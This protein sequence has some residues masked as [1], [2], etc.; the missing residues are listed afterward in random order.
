MDIDIDQPN[1]FR[2]PKNCVKIIALALRAEQHILVKIQVH[3]FTNICF[4]IDSC[5]RST[6][7]TVGEQFENGDIGRKQ[8]LYLSILDLL[9]N[10]RQ[11]TSYIIKTIL[12]WGA[13]VMIWMVMNH[14][15]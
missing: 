3:I 13:D 7:K 9:D 4:G 1:H 14:L 5:Y 6:V 15:N 8:I 11:N 10:K 2:M 12:K